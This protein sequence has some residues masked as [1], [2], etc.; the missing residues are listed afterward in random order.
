MNRKTELLHQ[1][2]RE[3]AQVAVD[4]LIA[5]K[6]RNRRYSDNAVQAEHLADCAG[7]VASIV[8]ARMVKHYEIRE[9]NRR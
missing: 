5:T 3:D 1:R 2:I 4:H 7:E 9:R 6:I 8:V